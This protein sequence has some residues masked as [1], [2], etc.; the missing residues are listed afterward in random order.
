[1]TTERNLRAEIVD[2]RLGRSGQATRFRGGNDPDDG[3][4]GSRQRDNDLPAEGVRVREQFLS[5][6]L[7]DYGRTGRAPLVGG[8][9]VAA[10]QERDAESFEEPGR[11]ARLKDDLPWFIWLSRMARDFHSAASRAALVR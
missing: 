1:M 9:D 7:I 10:A 2:P 3:E 5:D 4:S 11:S 6:N 8:G